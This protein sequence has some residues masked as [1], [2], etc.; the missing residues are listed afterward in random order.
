CR[1]GDAGGARS[2]GDTGAKE[3]ARWQVSQLHLAVDV[4]HAPLELEQVD[5][6][7]S[8]SRSQAIY[9]AAKVEVE[10]LLQ[11]IE[12]GEGDEI[13]GPFTMDWDVLYA[14]DDSEAFDTF[15]VTLAGSEKDLEPE[16]VAD[17]A[18]TVYRLGRWLS[19]M[20]FSPGGD[21]SL[22][23]YDKLLH[24]RLSGKRHMEPLWTS[25]DWQPGV[26]AT[27]HEARLRRSRA[28]SGGRD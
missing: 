18:A 20:T 23:L 25:A 15:G 27:R 8:R 5:R 11:A 19:G 26:P 24:G 28:G 21:V 9:H 7:V 3:P 17:R 2:V 10:H 1:Q 6:Y 16:P 22:V 12:R 4:A 14:G 13:L